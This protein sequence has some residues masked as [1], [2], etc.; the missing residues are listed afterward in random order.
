M[1]GTAYPRS[2]DASKQ[3]VAPSPNPRV[4]VTVATPDR[5]EAVLPLPTK[6][7]EW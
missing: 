7:Y 5:K 6:I 3:Q 4:P 1:G 2:G